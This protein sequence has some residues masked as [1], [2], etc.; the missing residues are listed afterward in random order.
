MDKSGEYWL[1]G[2]AWQNFQNR[3]LFTNISARH[4]AEYLEPECRESCG[5]I[6]WDA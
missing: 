6:I 5:L 1:H 3:R 4:A 2:H